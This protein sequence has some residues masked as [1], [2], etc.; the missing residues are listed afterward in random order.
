MPAIDVLTATAHE[1]QVLLD[2]G[3]V[4]SQQ[5]VKVY[6]GQIRKHNH[7]GM[8][9]NALISVAPEESALAWAKAMDDERKASG[10][11]GPLHGIPIVVKDTICTPSLGLPT[12]CGSYALVDAK[13]SK[14]AI[15]VNRLLAAGALIIGKANLSV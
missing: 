12:T 13:A 10:K 15:I 8:R 7:F 3:A 5:L 2:K 6:M 4:N 11:R 9:L 1:L 14:D